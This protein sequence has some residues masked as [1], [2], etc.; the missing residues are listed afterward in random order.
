[1]HGPFPNIAFIP[2]NAGDYIAAGT[3]ALGAGRD[4]ID[5]AALR[6]GD[7]QSTTDAAKKLVAALKAARTTNP[8]DRF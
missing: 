8:A 7:T 5:A 6:N 3:F 1:L 2:S 4:L